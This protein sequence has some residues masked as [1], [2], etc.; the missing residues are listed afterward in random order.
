MQNNSGSWLYLAPD[1]KTVLEGDESASGVPNGSTIISAPG[2]EV[3]N[4]VVARYN[5]KEKLAAP[6]PEAKA[7]AKA[8]ADVQ[9][10]HVAQAA[11]ST[12]AAETA[13]AAQQPEPA[14]TPHYGMGGRPHGRGN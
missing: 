9:T 12:K 11:E 6:D 10:K 5:L 4:D 8:A 1:G 13:Q 14:R 7:K 2:A 3:P